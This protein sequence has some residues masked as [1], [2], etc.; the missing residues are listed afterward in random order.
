MG[1][2]HGATSCAVTGIPAWLRRP[3]S[4]R[5]LE[6]GHRFVH[7]PAG[8]R[9]V[10][11]GVVN[12]TP[13]SFSDG[14]RFLAVDAARARID[15]LVSE[16][17][18]VIEIGGES[19]RPA[20]GAYGQ[21]Y[22]PVDAP[23]QIARTRG[24]LEHAVATSLPVAIDT[25]LP[26][27]ARAALDAGATIVNDVSCLADPELARVAGAAGAWFVLMHA[28]PG[29]VSTWHDV[30]AEV[31]RE[32]SVAR[33]RAV[34][35]GVVPERIVMDPGLGFGKGADENLALLAGLSRFHEL[36]HPLYVGAS[37]KA[38]IGV[39][40]ER[41]G[42]ERSAA[43]ERVGGTIAACLAAA[44]RGAAVLRVHDVRALRQALAVEDAIHARGAA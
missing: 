35:E 6:S 11:V 40:E 15:Q 16:G 26:E 19:T 32:W 28:R 41:E 21:G 42:L 9:P 20:G 10:V 27:V 23:T 44:R 38:F 5:G 3:S 7:F 13:D 29:A 36:G 8:H 25:A 1:G 14:G 37:R 43:D 17:V 4:L 12:V 2:T 34:A 31:S 39:C 33:D 24:A 18:D 30:V 22:A